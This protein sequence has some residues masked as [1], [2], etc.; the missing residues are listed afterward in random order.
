ML[1]FSRD[2]TATGVSQRIQV[3]S[4]YS[5]EGS[6]ANPDSGSKGHAVGF[7]A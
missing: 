7:F 5:V 4:Y 2:R 6:G 3:S 1:I